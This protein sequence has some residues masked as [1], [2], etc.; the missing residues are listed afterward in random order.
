MN[1]YDAAHTLAKAIRECDEYKNY[2]KLV[3]L[4]KEDAEM[5]EILENVAKFQADVAKGQQEGKEYTAEEKKELGEKFD[6]YLAN[7]KVSKFIEA[8][9]NF[10]RLMADVNKIVVEPIQKIAE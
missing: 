6:T 7:E 10:E 9:M 2:Q 3:K 5:K 8:E 1:T 4:A